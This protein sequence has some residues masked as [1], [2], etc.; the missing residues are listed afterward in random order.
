MSSFSGSQR[1]PSRDSSESRCFSCERVGQNVTKLIASAPTG[2]FVCDE[3]VEEAR[4]GLLAEK[5]SSRLQYHA[6]SG[7]GPPCSFCGKNNVKCVSHGGFAICH[8]CV[9]LC[10]EMIAESD[11][12][13]GNAPSR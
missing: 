4:N 1:R 8:E 12:L 9:R 2:V 6:P 7:D 5:S 11:R 10:R 13:E 3:C